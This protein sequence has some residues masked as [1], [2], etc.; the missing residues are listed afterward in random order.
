MP[1]LYHGAGSSQNIEP[2]HVTVSVLLASLSSLGHISIFV[3]A[4]QM[5]YV[6]RKKEVGG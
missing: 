4:D 3:R 1:A 2:R 6:Y 5:V